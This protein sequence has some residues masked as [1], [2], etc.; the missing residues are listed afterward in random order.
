MLYVDIPTRPDIRALIEE[1]ADACV[2]LY[3]STTPETQHVGASRIV[4]GNLVKRALEQLDAIGFDKRRRALLSEQF[5][6][7][8]DDDNFWNFQAHSLAVLATPDTIRTFRLPNR[9]KDTAQV[10]DRF[11]LKP[12]L[13]AVT[14]PPKRAG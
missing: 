11:H 4:F 2:S 3:L 8:I 9:L 13:R 5:D 10:A 1:R 6:D 14:F 12:L 7:L